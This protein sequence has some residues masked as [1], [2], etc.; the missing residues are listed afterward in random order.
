MEKLLLFSNIFSLSP[1]HNESFFFFPLIASDSLIGEQREIESEIERE[2]NAI[3]DKAFDNQFDRLEDEF[4]CQTRREKEREF[5]SISSRAR[6]RENHVRR[7][8]AP[9][10]LIGRFESRP[11]RDWWAGCRGKV[12][13]I[14]Q[15]TA[16]ALTRVNALV[17]QI[18]NLSSTSC[19]PNK[20][21]ERGK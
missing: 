21:W 3:E 8:R 15:P 13:R 20:G 7:F 18:Q 2:T 4:S 17:C 10:F 11:A 19:P 6:R 12:K 16:L 5:F 1:R 9:P 14:N